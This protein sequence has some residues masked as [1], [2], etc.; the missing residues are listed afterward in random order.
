MVQGKNTCAILASREGRG[1]QLFLEYVLVTPNFRRSRRVCFNVSESYSVTKFVETQLSNPCHC[2][3]REHPCSD[4]VCTCV[5]HT[6]V[7]PHKW[8][9]WLKAGTHQ[10]S[11]LDKT[12]L[13]PAFPVLGQLQRERGG[14]TGRG[15][16]Y[17][18]ITVHVTARAHWAS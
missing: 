17:L 8:G 4:S 15:K 12:W 2:D 9:W 6:C 7:A 5:L 13:G 11:F 1:K 3:S 18:R 16:H 10:Q 14:A